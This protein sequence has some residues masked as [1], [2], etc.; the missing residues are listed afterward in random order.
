MSSR[1]DTLRGFLITDPADIFTHY[2]IAL[3]YV[4]EKM[5]PEAIAKFQEVLHRD[6]K[7]LPA[8]QQLGTLLAQLDRREEAATILQQ[9]VRIAAKS[10]DAH[11][12]AEMQEALDELM[13]Q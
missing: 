4:S 3:E 11:A 10:G 9:G 1:L 6:E 7:Y 13:S 5:Y 12:R 2:A 8:Y